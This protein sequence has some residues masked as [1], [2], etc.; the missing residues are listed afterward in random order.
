M[1]NNSD[2]WMVKSRLLMVDEP[3]IKESNYC[4]WVTLEGVTKNILFLFL[5]NIFGACTI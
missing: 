1:N 3:L 2:N 4:C 5:S